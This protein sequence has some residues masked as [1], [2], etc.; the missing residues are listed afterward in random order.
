MLPDNIEGQWSEGSDCLGRSKHWMV[1]SRGFKNKPKAQRT[2]TK[3]FAYYLP[4]KSSYRQW[5]LK[6]H[7]YGV[8]LR[9]QPFL[10]YLK[11]VQS[12]II[13]RVCKMGWAWP[14][15]S[16]WAQKMGQSSPVWWVRLDSRIKGPKSTKPILAH[17][18]FKYI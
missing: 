12:N 11:Y 10:V 9:N 2:L 5:N 6:S 14:V 18:Y 8:S 17:H 4:T 7:S 3:V 1:G 16:Y 13:I 15:S